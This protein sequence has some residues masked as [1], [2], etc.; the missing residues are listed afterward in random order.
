MRKQTR[1]KD[2]SHAKQS[3][4]QQNTRKQLQTKHTQPTT[5]LKQTKEKQSSKT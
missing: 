3:G 4:K 1:D 5:K 2:H